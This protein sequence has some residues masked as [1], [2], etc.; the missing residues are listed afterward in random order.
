[1]NEQ[2]SLLPS[3]SRRNDEE[4]VG[5]QKMED[6]N[7]AV[8]GPG[9]GVVEDFGS[10]DGVDTRTTTAGVIGAEIDVEHA[11]NRLDQPDTID[12]VAH[13]ARKDLERERERHTPNPPQVQEQQNQSKDEDLKVAQN[14]RPN[15]YLD[16]PKR[17]NDRTRTTSQAITTGMKMDLDKSIDIGAPRGSAGPD[18][19]PAKMMY[20]E[21]FF[22]ASCPFSYSLPLPCPFLPFLFV[23][24]LFFCPFFQWVFLG[25]ILERPFFTV[26]TPGI[27]L[28]WI[29]GLSFHY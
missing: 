29:M 25:R 8:S 6:D 26:R 24:F 3:H 7:G 1:M 13:D 22:L 19:F 15:G 20:G 17:P 5:A 18:G 14:T 10:K 2:G 27:S 16:A 23:S 9:T 21:F 28:S 11:T 4:G 12:G